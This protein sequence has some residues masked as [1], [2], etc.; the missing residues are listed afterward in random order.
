MKGNKPKGAGK[1]SFDLIDQ[2]RF[3]DLLN[4]AAG[5]ILVDLGSGQGNYT[6]P[7]AKAVGPEGKVYAFDAWAQGIEDLKART[8][9][10]GL[11]NV[12]ASVVD[13]RHGLP[14]ADRTADACLMA[15]VLHDLVED[16]LGER[17]VNECARVLKP[18]GRLVVVE[19]KKIDG[20]PGPPIGIRLSPE[21][22]DGLIAP[23]G[24]TMGHVDGVGPYLYCTV[25]VLSLGE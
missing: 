6:L 23:A 3:L 7:A 21:D 18:G 11:V 14:L 2:R 10:S 16:N 8:A 24:F 12:D 22:V 9:E 1:S 25:A 13:I 4:P 19:F 15:T 17:A 5:E 20:P